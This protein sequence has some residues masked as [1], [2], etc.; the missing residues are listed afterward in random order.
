M[1]NIRKLETDLWESADL[2]RAGSKLTSNQYCM[3]VLGLLFLRYAYSR[4]KLVEA[5]ILANRPMR[6][7]RVMPVEAGDFKAKSAL[8]LPREAQYP[9]LVGL[10][11]DIASADLHDAEGHPLNTLGEV[12]NNAMRLVE[13]QR[14]QLQGV[15]PRDYT[16]F[17]DDLLSELL[18][19]FNN[20]ALDDI[21]GDV[22]GRI[23]EYFL[24]K[25]AKN[26]ASDDGVFFTPK[27]LVKMIVNVLEPKSGILLDPACGSGGMFVQTGDFVNNA[28]MNANNQMTF[29]GQEKVEYNAK[30]CLMNM[31]VH[32]LTGVIKSGND[33]NTFYHDAHNL[34]GE[35]DYVMANPPFNVDKV[36]AESAENA[37]R[38][39]FGLPAV[40]KQKE[41]GN[42]NYLWI[43]Y[44]YAY[45]NE[46][47]RAG[48][49]MASSATDSQGKDK[50]IREKLI[51]SGH[52]DVMVSVGNNFF[53]TKSL[54][55]SLWFFDRGKR[56]ELRD[57]VLFIDSRNYFTV[58]DR[59][60]NEWSAWQLKNLNAIVWLYR[61][62]TE[63]YGRLLQEYF[64]AL[65]GA[66]AELREEIGV[67]R[68]L[69][70]EERQKLFDE[71]MREAASALEAAG[72]AELR[73]PEPV[74]TALGKFTAAIKTC[75]EAMLERFAD[76]PAKRQ[77][78]LLEELDLGF[79]RFS[80]Y[81]KALE[82]RR[83]GLASAI[84]ERIELTL[85]EGHWLV[86]KFKDGVYA[87]IPGL[88]KIA[89][90][91]EVEEKNWSLTPGA[92]VGVAEVE[93]DGV[94]FAERMREIHAELLSLQAESN[95]LMDKIAKNFEELGI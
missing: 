72:M 39:P 82:A 7:G 40:N 24:N 4:F 53:Y 29:F 90:L 74:K 91:A 11:A 83:E 45:L 84:R 34:A 55:C 28:G 77:K 62:E 52:V 75:S 32:G 2:L 15:L 68:V 22:F 64:A 65:R 71:A 3:P 37:G 14:E 93:D 18:R 81:K 89:A 27:S 1:I 86:S 66:M 30:L 59:T 95:A 87:D 41:V 44:F 12:V 19:I 10:P 46:R 63:K 80:V 54:P 49:V 38:L 51:E 8:F 94:D 50:D 31:A 43:S 13:A 76:L 33:A 61:G 78:E 26:I 60:L 85:D 58:V 56:E 25:F 70:D 17:T 9:Y 20:G 48:F 36:K 47:G 79:N 21:G 5:D 69:L 73:E 6:N 57:K 16:M 88:C 23:Y 35:C 42:G 67:L 92:Y